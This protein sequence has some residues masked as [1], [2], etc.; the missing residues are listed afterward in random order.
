MQVVTFSWAR[1]LSS[2]CSRRGG[3][4]RALPG[5]VPPQTLPGT[6]VRS[7]C[8]RSSLSHA[9][10]SSKSIL[11]FLPCNSSS[12]PIR[13]KTSFKDLKQT[14]RREARDGREDSTTCADE[15]TSEIWG[16]FPGTQHRRR[17]PEQARCCAQTS[18]S[19]GVGF[20]ERP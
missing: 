16:L 13:S 20:G 6:R 14:G 8:S 15:Q 4:P 9:C 5:G 18:A 17:R 10:C 7:R 12:P 1:A 3:T 19:G 11:K 2:R